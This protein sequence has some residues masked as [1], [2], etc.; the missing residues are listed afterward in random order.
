VTIWKAA[1]ATLGARTPSFQIAGVR[2][3]LGATNSSENAPNGSE[4]ADIWAPGRQRSGLV[5]SWRPESPGAPRGS[6]KTAGI[7]APLQGVRAPKFRCWCTTWT[8]PQT[9]CWIYLL[10][11]PSK[12]NNLYLSFL[13]HRWARPGRGGKCCLIYMHFRFVNLFYYSITCDGPGLGRMYLL[14]SYR[15]RW[16]GNDHPRA[17]NVLRRG[18]GTVAFHSVESTFRLYKIA[19]TISSFQ[20]QL[21]NSRWQFSLGFVSLNFPEPLRR[22]NLRNIPL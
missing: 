19:K 2:A 3:P 10:R 12:L 11:W 4:I 13:P 6:S 9:V 21:H 8:C 17:P 18:N 7:R 1:I 14:Y 5:A 16:Q 20:S 22:I 15:L